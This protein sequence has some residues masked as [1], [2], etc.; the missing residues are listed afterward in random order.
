MEN[1]KEKIE[2]YKER[3]SVFRDEAIKAFII[4]SENTYHFCYIKDVGENKIGVYEFTGKLEGDA[5]TILFVDII[6][7]VRY[8]EEGV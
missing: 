1:I 2:R 5:T 7:F 4:D 3:A 6:K 8:R